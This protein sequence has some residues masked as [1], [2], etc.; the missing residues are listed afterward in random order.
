MY[1]R[2]L[3]GVAL[4]AMLLFPTA[5]RAAMASWDLKVDNSTDKYVWI[6]VYT[7]NWS[8]HWS[9]SKATCMKPK[10]KWDYHYYD[11]NNDEVKVRAEVRDGASC[12]DG[13]IISD[14][15][16]YRKEVRVHK[17]EADMYYHAGRY[18]IGIR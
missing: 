18:F 1:K 10:S 4:M 6:T 12:S 14:T 13:R 5:G 8:S 2:L 15:F 7:A 11:S 17:L 9:I 16:D 3:L